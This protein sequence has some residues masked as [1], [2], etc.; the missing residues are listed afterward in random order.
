MKLLAI[1]HAPQECGEQYVM[2]INLE[3]GQPIRTID[4]PEGYGYSGFSTCTYYE[5][6]GEIYTRRHSGNY[7]PQVGDINQYGINKYIRLKEIKDVKPWSIKC[8]K[9][10]KG[11]NATLIYEVCRRRVGI[12]FNSS[13]D[14]FKRKLEEQGIN[15]KGWCVYKRRKTPFFEFLKN[16]L[17]NDVVNLISIG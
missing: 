13:E 3:D 2:L 8:L 1:Y 7:L 11:Y 12:R 10:L 16:I 5:P 15:M 4:I 14:S 9:G 17:P 6:T